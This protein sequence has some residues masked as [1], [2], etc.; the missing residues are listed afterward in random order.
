MKQCNN[1][2]MKQ[3]SAFAGS[4]LILQIHLNNLKNKIRL[5]HGELEI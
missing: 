3:M 5:N 2:A 1:E 4:P